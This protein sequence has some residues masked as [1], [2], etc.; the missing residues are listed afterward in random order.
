M[1]K[2]TLLISLF[3]HSWLSFG[4]DETPSKV[5]KN[6]INFYATDAINGLYTLSYE[7]ALGKHISVNLGFGYK[8]EEGL[9][10]LSGIDT[11]QLKT[12]NLTYSG[13]KIV[14]EFRYYLNESLN[15]AMLS[16]F[17]FG[18]YLKYSDF[19]SDLIG[20]FINS[21]GES[22]DIAYKGDIAIT[23]V[24]LMVGY[25]LPIGKHFFVDFLIAG[26]GSGSYKFKLDNTIPPPDEFYE[27]LNQA[28]ENY[29]IFDLINA[30][31]EFNDRNLRSNFSVLSFRYGI[32]IGYSF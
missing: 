2:L 19:K 25:K 29:S 16:G 13:Y 14:P 3:V 27:V 32:S 9:I 17:Y 8:T 20:T 5:E 30:D 7:R 11:D 22:F 6:Q 4:Q 28:L 12:N 1:K 23:S 24:G 26:P 31:F 18:A 21:E 15:G 10:V